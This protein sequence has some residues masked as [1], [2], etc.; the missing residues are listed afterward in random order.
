MI[1]RFIPIAF[2]TLIVFSPLSAV[3]MDFE[4]GKYEITSKVEMPGMAMPA[5]TMT[6]CL[7]QEEPVPDNSMG[8]QG[9]ELSDMKKD[10]NT[11]TWTMECN[12]QGQKVTTSGETKYSEDSFEGVM[13]TKMG[14]HAGNMTIKTQISGKRIGPCE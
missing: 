5:Q 13:T 9:C 11:I 12:Q 4:P 7:T 6:Q 1:K 10:G 2:L 14:P 3:C 8:D